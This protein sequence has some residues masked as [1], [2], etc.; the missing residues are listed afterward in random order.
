MSSPVLPN[1]TSSQQQNALATRLRALHKPGD[2]LVLC[3]VYDAATAALVAAHPAAKAIATASYAIAAT[4]GVED[5]DMT[6]E[7][8]LASLTAVAKVAQTADLP[9]TVDVQ[10]G[11]EDVG[12]TV[13]AII[14]LGAVGCNI[15]DLDNATGKLR[16]VDDAVAR[17]RVAL[18]AA[19]EAGVPEFVLNAR[20]D[21]LGYNG[22]VEDAIARGKAFLE[23]GAT[24]VFVWGPNGRG[25]R[26]EEV[27]KLCSAFEGRLNVKLCM[28]DGFLTVPEL[29]EIGVARISVGPEL[30]RAA[31]RAYKNG[32]DQLLGAV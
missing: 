21:T 22:T 18:A 13:R 26:T 23:A 9:L 16:T 30:Y 20:T 29:K 4:H 11:Y 7:Q 27:H 8:N 5:D 12:A 28:G 10:D 19:H 3:N 6:L 15:E 32:V 14:S 31:M 25:V 2:P 17:L 24:T 1:S